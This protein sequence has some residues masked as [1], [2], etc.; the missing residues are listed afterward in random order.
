MSYASEEQQFNE[1]LSQL[2]TNAPK[3]SSDA[4]EN[5]IY[6][7]GQAVDKG[8]SISEEI[9]RYT[10]GWLLDDR[11]QKIRDMRKTGEIN[12]EEYMSFVE[13]DSR[14]MKLPNYNALAKLAKSRGA[15]VQTDEEIRK[16]MRKTLM[17]RTEIANEI[18]SRQTTGG[19]LAELAGGVVGYGLEPGVA[20]AIPLEAFFIGRSAYTLSQ[21]AT[22]LGR[23]AR[24]AGISAATNA[25]VETGLQPILFNWRE[26][27][28]QDMSWGEA[29]MNVASVAVM[30]GAITGA[31]S[32]LKRKATFEAEQFKASIK[33]KI[34]AGRADELTANE[35]AY[36]LKDIKETAKKVVDD[37]EGEALLK[38]TEEELSSLPK[39][40]NAKEHLQEMDELDK[41]MNEAPAPNQRD[42]IADDIADDFEDGGINDVIDDM[43]LEKDFDAAINESLYMK[44]VAMRNLTDDNPLEGMF[45][46]DEVKVATKN[47]V[48]NAITQ[49]KTAD[50]KI[51]TIETCL[52]GEAALF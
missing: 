26:E 11:N 15:D 47:D 2:A 19:F 30:S 28:G 22:R 46:F 42:D 40:K 43:Q 35:L 33:E 25:A 12:D 1:D 27:I 49:I 48:G 13:P 36:T 24:I 44:D 16:D 21:A 39:D 8:L 41:R 17:E 38:Q 34:K 52:L 23:G 4:G 6:G 32:T 9:V 37:P 14:G 31:A 10:G 51:K 20:A 7:V 50:K 5:F 18:F 29:I 45:G 3:L